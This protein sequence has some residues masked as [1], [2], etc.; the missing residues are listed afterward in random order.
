MMIAKIYYWEFTDDSIA[1]KGL[2]SHSGNSGRKLQLG[3]IVN[4]FY[5]QLLCHYLVVCSDNVFKIL[6]SLLLYNH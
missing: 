6:L 1:Y 3:H 4:M 5:L 2:M